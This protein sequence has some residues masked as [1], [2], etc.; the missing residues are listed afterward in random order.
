MKSSDKQNLI[1]RP[2]VVVI[3]GHVD[4]GKSKLLDYIRKS[5]IVENETGG[6]TQHIGAYETVY[7]DPGGKKANDKQIT[8]LDTPGH[9]AFAQMRSRGAKVADIAILVVAADEGVKPQTLE[10]FKAIQKEKIPFMVAINKIDKPNANPEKIKKELSAHNIFVE[11]FGGTV[12]SVNISAKEGEGMPELLETILLLAEMEELKADPRQ[13]AEGVVIESHLDPKRGIS[14]TLLILNGTIKR[15]E[16]ISSGQATAPVR[17]FEDFQGKQIEEK[18]FSSPVKITGFNKL[19][20]IGVE[21]KS[22]AT[23]KEAEVESGKTPSVKNPPASGEKTLGVKENSTKLTIPLVVKTDVS[24][25]LEAIEY[26]LKKLQNEEISFNL[27]RQKAGNISKDDI[28]IAS[29]APNS[30]II[31]FNVKTDNNVN[32]FA[33]RSNVEIKQFDIIYKITDWLKEVTAQ[34]QLAI[35]KEEIIGKIKILRIFGREGNKQII[36]GKVVS[37]K[38]IEGGMINIK[39]RGNMIGSGKITSLQKGKLPAA[40]VEEGEQ[41]GAMAEAKLEI[42]KDDELEIFAKLD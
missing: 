13:K 3:M 33:K 25:S 26:E 7:P 5:N 9:E 4:H 12:P 16:F 42:A 18:S 37:G 11:S 6:I 22:F 36:G 35:K 10:A 32:D 15:G 27:L 41:F 1:I 8:F 24:G 14:A 39:R 20:K 29:S 40:E 2:P 34:K 21:F 28:K 23:K 38:I 17:I 19:P 31:G 30:F